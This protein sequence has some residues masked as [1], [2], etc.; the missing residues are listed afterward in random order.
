MLKLEA[1]AKGRL[2]TL[3]ETTA[4]AK[5][6][7][8][9]QEILILEEKSRG[10]FEEEDAFQL[11]V[12][13]SRAQATLRATKKVIKKKGASSNKSSSNSARKPINF[14]VP[15]ARKAASSR[16]AAKKKPVASSNTFAMM[17][18]SDSDSD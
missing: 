1:D 14:V 3:K 18:D 13:A 17:M 12:E 16:P 10:W 8:I 9:E 6:D 2:L 4:I 5:K 15:G 7:E 11:R